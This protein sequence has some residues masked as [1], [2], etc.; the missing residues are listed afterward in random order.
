MA[1]KTKSKSLGAS[2]VSGYIQ[3]LGPGLSPLARRLREEIESLL[4]N[5]RSKLYH[6]MPVWFIGENAVVGFGL[7]AQ[8][9]L[10]LLFWN[11]QAFNEPKLKAI[12]SF[13][14]A[15][16]EFN[17]LSEIPVPALRRWIQKSGKRIWDFA[18]LKRG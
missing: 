15:Q 9:T 16:I 2:T 3:K 18:S 12:G 5:A 10:K 4:P 14:A 7:T 17:E 11:G 1:M 8:G 13:E 6:G